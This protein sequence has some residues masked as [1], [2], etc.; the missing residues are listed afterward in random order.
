MRSFLE[1]MLSGF[2]RLLLGALHVAAAV[3]AIRAIGIARQEQPP[4]TITYES[5]SVQAL[6][7]PAIEA[8]TYPWKEELPGWDV[9]FVVGAGNIAGYTWSQ[10]QRIEVFV[11]PGATSADLAR[12]LAHELGHAVDVT[13]NSGDE[14]RAWLVLRNAESAPWWPGNGLADFATGAGDF[15]EAFAVWQ[16][17]ADDYRGELGPPPTPEQLELLRELSFD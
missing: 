8:I 2:Y 13:K 5:A 12:I 11:R 7:G 14:R 10:E 3:I 15:A 16:V 9:E 17:G 4:A 1:A 6:G